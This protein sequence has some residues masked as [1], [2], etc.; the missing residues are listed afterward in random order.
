MGTED[1][2]GGVGSYSAVDGS[3]AWRGDVWAGWLVL[4]RED[5]MRCLVH[6]DTDRG[7]V[8]SGRLQASLT[9]AGVDYV[10]TWEAPEKVARAYAKVQGRPETSDQ[11]THRRK[12][13]AEQL[14]DAGV[15]AEWS[16]QKRYRARQGGASL[17]LL[18]DLAVSQGYKV[19]TSA[20][21][22]ELIED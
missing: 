4:E 20:D 15:L 2:P 11:I 9:T 7:Q 13:L 22:V 17:E 16:K 19:E 8:R 5:G 14:D 3:G 6:A 18:I 1:I 21:G 12:L 10:T